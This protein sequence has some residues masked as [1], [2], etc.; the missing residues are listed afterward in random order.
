MNH[1]LEP[2]RHQAREHLHGRGERDPDPLDI[3]QHAMALAHRDLQRLTAPMR[4]AIARTLAGCG[5]V[6]YVV[7]MTPD[8]PR[9]EPLDIEPRTQELLDLYREH[10]A[11]VARGLGLTP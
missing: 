4:D 8:G 7:T 11:A 3:E 6:G 2:F 10:Y 9:M 1:A 5:T